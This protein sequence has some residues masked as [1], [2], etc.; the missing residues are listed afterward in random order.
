[1]EETEDWEDA[2]PIEINP[3]PATH[4]APRSIIV[5]DAPS[6]HQ[7]IIRIQKRTTPLPTKQGPTG[8]AKPKTMAE[9]QQEY[10]AVKRNIFK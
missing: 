8:T 10:E 4:I 2:E 9:K 5:N 6:L 7:P 1:M 3:Q